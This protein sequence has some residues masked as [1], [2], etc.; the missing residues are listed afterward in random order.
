MKKIIFFLLLFLFFNTQS[1]SKSKRIED[2]IGCKSNDL[3]F[4]TQNYDKLNI[5]KIEIDINKYKK[6]SSNNIKIL[7]NP[8]RFTP[9]RLKKRFKGQVVT[10][11]E[12]GTI[13][14]DQA[15]IRHSGDAKDHIALRD[16]LII[17]SLDV[18]LQH[19]NIKGITQFKLFKPDVRGNLDD[20]II[21]N[22]LL[23]DFGYLAP[24]SFKVNSRVNETESIMLFQEKA[25]KELLEFNKRREGPIL[26]GDQKYFFKLV[27]NI[28]DNNLSNWSVGTPFL[29][30]K[31][32]KVMLAKIT[33]PNVLERSDNHKYIFLESLSRLNYIYS[34]WA[35]RFQ[36][37]KNNFFFF[38]YDL[39][40]SLLASGNK[41]YILKL[42][43]FN[44]FL[45]STNSHHGLGPDSRK[46]YWNS[47]ENYFEPILYDAN[48]DIDSN[49]ASTTTSLV[50]YPISEYF[51]LSFENLE[52][53][54]SEVNIDEFYKA[55]KSS[56]LLLDKNLI[57][58]KLNKILSNLKNLQKNY[59]NQIDNNLIE[60]N[61]YKRL[62]DILLKFHKNITDIDPNLNLITHD[63]Q[64]GSF[65]KCNTEL[66]NCV[67]YLI[68]SKELMQ[69]VEGDL[70]VENIN[71]Q[72]LGNKN[73][74]HY[75]EKIDKLNQLSFL[76]ST[77]YYDNNIEIKLDETNKRIDFYQNK[78][79]SR[80]LIVNG[81]I[82][83]YEIN[84]SGK[85]EIKKHELNE[86]YPPNFPIDI[87]NLTGC[88]TFLNLN[89]SK[90]TINSLNTDCEDSVNLINVNGDIKRIR[91][92]NSF[93]DGLDSD[94]SNVQISDLIIESAGNDC[95]DV[96]EGAYT[97]KNLILRNCGDKGLSVGEKSK[98]NVENIF[99]DK[100]NIGIASKDSSITSIDGVS[101]SDTDFCFSAYKKKQ[102][103]YG[104]IIQASNIKTAHCIKERDTDI[105]STILIN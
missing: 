19:G 44:L 105:N 14:V 2:F 49:S 28:P 91:I 32:M 6:W 39:D 58:L 35:N 21:Q 93:R 27:E 97:L 103:Y 60:H 18:N 88:L 53:K 90:V 3:I 30:N 17:Q 101:F 59:L 61:K 70:K 96:S 1:H 80:V 98:V 40:N 48:P 84:F 78:S 24:R 12:D 25:T 65:N 72:F 20:V 71:Y 9:D 73:F 62:D 100:A 7:T 54:I 15:N 41:N 8:T 55:L 13:C 57:N 89:L 43:F 11:Y 34:Y 74:F 63:S 45:Q 79:G 77:I 52:K 82:E 29:R 104:G 22:Q 102:E 38:D 66:I 68:T 94:F 86:R 33:N 83:N 16:N 99:I 92:S 10:S 23:R 95:L 37:E 42:D 46:F 67:D 51:F 81:Q 64:K 56:G 50:R 36:D 26:E 85:K 87:N 76:N 75:S 4:F 47:L 69:L 31:T 5:T